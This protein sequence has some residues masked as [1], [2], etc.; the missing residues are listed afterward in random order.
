MTFLVSTAF[1]SL[2]NNV[3]LTLEISFIS[4]YILTIYCNR[5][6]QDDETNRIASHTEEVAIARKISLN[7]KLSN[8]I[9]K[10]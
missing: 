2:K 10:L 6:Y 9:T 3:S 8:A 7:E 1:F 4:F 5:A